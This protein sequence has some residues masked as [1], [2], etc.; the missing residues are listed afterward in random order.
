MYIQ[1]TQG[2]VSP[3][4]VQQILLHCTVCVYIYTIY[5]VS[6]EECARLREGVPYGKV[7][8]YNGKHLSPKLNGYGDNGQ[9]KVWSS[10]G[11]TYCRYQLTSLSQSLSL[12]EVWYYV[13]ASYL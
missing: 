12:S 8:R 11:S 9:R 5:R 13:S 10:V 7:Y 3:G 1:Y 4:S 6:Q 2:L